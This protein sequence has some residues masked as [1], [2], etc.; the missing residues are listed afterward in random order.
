MQVLFSKIYDEVVGIL[1]TEIP[2][3]LT[4]HSTFHTLYVLEKAIHIAEK[5]GV[6]KK[7]VFLIK[8]AALYHD[9]GFI[10]GLENH[11]NESCSIAKKSLRK[12]G[13]AKED[14]D[15]I[16]GMIMATQIPQNPKTPLEEILADADLEYL[17][18]KHF[19]PFADLLY[20][21]M[22]FSNKKL[23]RTKWNKIQRTFIKNHHYHTDYC[24]RYK[25]FR[26]MRNL[27][28]L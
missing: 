1:N 5:T 27:E 12:F 19:I 26:K 23:T 24:R 21:E 6:K 8:V 9:I 13:L 28:M 17:A 11:E 2:K 16:L 7:D 22:R 18:T 15:K 20:K 10:K 25:A 3:N 14:I 4:Y